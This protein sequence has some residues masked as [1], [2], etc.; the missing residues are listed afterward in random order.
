MEKA[1][2][3][4]HYELQLI[5]EIEAQLALARE[6][7]QLAEGLNSCLAEIQQKLQTAITRNVIPFARRRN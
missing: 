5:E 2:K 1:R 6:L 4:E 3:K 7:A